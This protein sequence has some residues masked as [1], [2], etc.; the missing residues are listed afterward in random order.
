MNDK[1][2][3]KSQN[4]SVISIRLEDKTI[5]KIDELAGK[6]LISRNEFI[7]QCIAFALERVED[8]NKK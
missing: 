1:F 5:E 6:S 4:K 2:I 8:V 3:P 7:K